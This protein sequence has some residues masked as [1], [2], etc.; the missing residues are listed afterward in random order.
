MS[1]VILDV[2]NYDVW[3]SYNALSFII[4]GSGVRTAESLH[5]EQAVPLLHVEYR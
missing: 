5:G 3:I 4:S 2:V 1:K